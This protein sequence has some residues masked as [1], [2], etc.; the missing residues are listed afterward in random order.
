[1]KPRLK[2]NYQRRENSRFLTQ[3]VSLG[4]VPHEKAFLT[5]SF[6]LSRG[7]LAECWNEAK[8][9]VDKKTNNTTLLINK[10]L[11]KMN[12]INEQVDR[13]KSTTESYGNTL[14]NLKSKLYEKKHQNDKR[15]KNVNRTGDE[16]WT[17]EQMLK[18]VIDDCNL[19]TVNTTKELKI[20]QRSQ[21][22]NYNYLAKID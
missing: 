10:K 9:T 21:A 4:S 8:R 19:A 2:S 12:S 13:S 14:D 17:R 5:D 1:M 18:K 22:Y 16:G 6:D 20:F 15:R 11:S 7:Q 3:K